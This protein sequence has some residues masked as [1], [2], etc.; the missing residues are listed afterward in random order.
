MRRLGRQK[1]SADFQTNPLLVTVYQIAETLGWTAERVRDTL[2][3][4][5]L[6]EWGVYLNGPFSSRGRDMLLNGWLV[7]TVRSIMATKRSRPKFTDSL[8]PFDKAVEGYFTHKVK[9]QTS[10]GGGGGC[11]ITTKAEAAHMSQV[12]QKRYEKALNDYRAGRTPNTYGLYVNERLG[13]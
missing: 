5:E 13:G 8:F 4:A 12:W 6:C 10:V 1:P 11:R 7:H 3:P 9:A 2:T